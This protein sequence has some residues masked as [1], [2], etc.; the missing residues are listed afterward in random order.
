MLYH[1]WKRMYLNARKLSKINSREKIQVKWSLAQNKLLETWCNS[2]PRGVLSPPVSVSFGLLVEYSSSHAIVIIYIHEFFAALSDFQPTHCKASK[3]D[4]VW[5]VIDV[6]SF[7]PSIPKGLQRGQS[8][9]GVFELRCKSLWINFQDW[10]AIALVEIIFDCNRAD[11]YVYI[12]EHYAKP[13]H[14]TLDPWD[15]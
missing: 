11:K 2:L 14:F 3:T 5:T 13:I 1:I 12:S 7:I 6:D 4:C 10:F 9:N 15:C 8:Q